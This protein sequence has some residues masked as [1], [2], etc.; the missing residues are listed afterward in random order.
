MLITTRGCRHGMDP[1]EPALKQAQNHLP[2]NEAFGL[3]ARV[4]CSVNWDL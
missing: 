1:P 3:D 4:L 2:E